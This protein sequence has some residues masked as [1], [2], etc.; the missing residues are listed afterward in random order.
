MT[1]IVLDRD[2]LDR[3]RTEGG[4]QGRVLVVD[5][6]P[7]PSGR[8][9]PVPK[10]T[11]WWNDP[12]W[13]NRDTGAWGWH[14]S[15]E[16][17]RAFHAPVLTPDPEPVVRTTAREKFDLIYRTLMAEAVRFTQPDGSVAWPASVQR[18]LSEAAWKQGKAGKLTREEQVELLARTYIVHAANKQKENDQKQVTTTYHGHSAA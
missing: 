16:P 1:D 8:L 9:I 13:R 17:G 12:I 18:E 11:P 2:G 3:L 10:L 5:L 7:D 6:E 4:P 14:P 15:Y